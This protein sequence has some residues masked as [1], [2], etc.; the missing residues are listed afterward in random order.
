MKATQWLSLLKEGLLFN[1]E[2]A[3]WTEAEVPTTGSETETSSVSI[4]ELA[5]PQKSQVPPLQRFQQKEQNV[6]A[7]PPADLNFQFSWLY[8]WLTQL[9][10]IK[11]WFLGG[12]GA[13]ALS[14]PVYAAQE[15]PLEGD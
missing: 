11:P 3:S 6:E 13:V 10:Q 8:F 15:G 2:I 4:R 5:L 1:Q 14:V 12:L 9:I 7:C